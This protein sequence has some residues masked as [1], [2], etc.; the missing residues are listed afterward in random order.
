MLLTLLGLEAEE[1]AQWMWWSW[2]WLYVQGLEVQGL[3]VQA[4]EVQGLVRGQVLD[5]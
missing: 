3:E 1:L 4:L 2:S 5:S